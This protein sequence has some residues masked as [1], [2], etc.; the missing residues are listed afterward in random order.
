MLRYNK[1]INIWF[2]IDTRRYFLK[3]SY[4]MDSKIRKLF[5]NDYYKARRG[6]YNDWL[7]S[8]KGS[9][10]LI[11]LLDQIPRHIFRN[12]KKAYETDKLALM[13]LKK[14]IRKGYLDK[15]N[16][17]MR[18][19]MLMPFQHSEELKEQYRGIKYYDYYNRKSRNLD[20][21]FF[22]RSNIKHCEIIRS[23]GRFPKRNKYLGRKTTK[24]EKDYINK[25]LFRHF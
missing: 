15:M 12:S 16:N 4:K 11:L 5:E 21:E 25:T 9:L 23:F 7:K 10:A 13:V 3:N 22:L 8:A 19:F 18:G 2:S 1:I 17:M 14:S 6:E 24:Q 20:L